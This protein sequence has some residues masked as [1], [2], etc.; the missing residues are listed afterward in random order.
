MGAY[1]KIGGLNKQIV[2]S[3]I[4]RFIV[5]NFRKFIIN[6]TGGKNMS[7]K[8][9]ILIVDDDTYSLILL[10]EYLNSLNAKIYSATNGKEAV[11]ICKN[12]P[13]DLV[14]TDILMPEMNGIDAVKFIRKNNEEIKIIVQTASVSKEKTD[15][16]ISAGADAYIL[17]PYSETEL[18]YVISG[19]FQI[20]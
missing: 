17:K 8:L 19:I 6:N 18:L 2:H 3:F 4:F 5:F 15:E 1:Q 10:K 13:I 11:E 16:I 20:V 9:N 14:L 12:Q 7:E